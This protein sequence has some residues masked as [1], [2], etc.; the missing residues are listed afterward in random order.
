MP[1]GNLYTKG[2]ESI[3][4]HSFPPMIVLL[5]KKNHKTPQILST[6]SMRMTVYEDYKMILI[7]SLNRTSLGL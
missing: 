1:L 7:F 4:K 5:E 6:K 2:R 3:K